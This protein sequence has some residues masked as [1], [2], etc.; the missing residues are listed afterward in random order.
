MDR[1]PRFG[2]SLLKKDNKIITSCCNFPTSGL[3]RNFEICAELYTLVL[4]DSG[5]NLFSWRTRHRLLLIFQLCFVHVF[6]CH[7]IWDVVFIYWAKHFR[8]DQFLFVVYMIQFSL[9]VVVVVVVFVVFLK[10]LFVSLSHSLL[11]RRARV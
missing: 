5:P 3:Q 7:F 10:G 1:W 11:R 9:F 4:Y 2:S 8:L 6:R